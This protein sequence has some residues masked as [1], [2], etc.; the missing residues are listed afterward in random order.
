MCSAA[1]TDTSSAFWRWHRR[2]RCVRS[3]LPSLLQ[4]GRCAVHFFDHFSQMSQIRSFSAVPLVKRLS[5]DAAMIS[6]A[7]ISRITN[8][9]KSSRISSHVGNSTLVHLL[10]L[11]RTERPYSSS[12]TEQVFDGS[13][14]FPL[15]MAHDFSG[16]LPGPVIGRHDDHCQSKRQPLEDTLLIFER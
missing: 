1:S 9:L 11:R 4:K 6:R 5:F 7:T 16:R 13:A 8:G 10:D 2:L 15:S 14:L 12:L 3:A